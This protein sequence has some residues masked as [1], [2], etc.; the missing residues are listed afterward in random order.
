MRDKILNWLKG[1]AFGSLP[2]PHVA[3]FDGSTEV[4][5]GIRPA[6][7]LAIAFNAPANGAQGRIINQTSTVNFGDADSTTDVS[8]AIVLDAATSGNQLFSLPRTGGVKTFTAGNAVKVKDGS[9]ESIGHLENAVKDAILNFVRGSSAATAPAGLFVALYNNSTEV[10]TQIRPAG[11]V[12]VT[13]GTVA[14]G[15]V[16][17]SV[18]VDFGEAAN[19]QD[20]TGFRIFDAQSGGNALTVIRAFD[21]IKTPSINDETI[22]PIGALTFKID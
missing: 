8:A 9:F 16:V 18:A 3:F 13:L 7:R 19:P 1:T 2:S 17:N 11:R 12:A 20:F 6:G 14:S 4:T 21:D 22:F 5:T 15:E 10:T